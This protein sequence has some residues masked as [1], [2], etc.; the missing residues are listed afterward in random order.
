MLPKP[1]SG[2]IM[3]RVL[4]AFVLDRDP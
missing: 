3:L 1:R 4:K 2:N